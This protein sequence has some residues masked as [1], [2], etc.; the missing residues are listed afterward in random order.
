MAT[1]T[2]KDRPVAR[3]AAAGSASPPMTFLMV[4]DN[5]GLYCWTILDSDGE[6]LAHSRPYATYDDAAQAALVVRD[7]AGSGRL[8]LGA[9]PA[10]ATQTER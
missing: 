4:E 9:A 5:L 3:A 1:A 10:G 2:Q 8:D 6:S 7:G